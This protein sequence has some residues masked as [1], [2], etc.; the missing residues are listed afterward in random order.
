MYYVR[1]TMEYSPRYVTLGS[2]ENDL[3]SKTDL[4]KRLGYSLRHLYRILPDLKAAGLKE[5]KL[6]PKSNPRFSITNIDKV[7][8]RLTNL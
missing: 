1:L 6:T 3:I 8:T 2:M 7:L 5:I 4:A